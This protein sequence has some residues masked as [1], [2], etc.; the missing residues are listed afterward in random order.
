MAKKVQAKVLNYRVIIEREHYPNGTP[1]YTAFVPTLGVADYGPTIDKVLKSLKSG[2][3]LAVE[4]LV[5]AGEEVPID[6][7]EETIVVNTRVSAPK[8]TRLVPA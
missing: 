4:C 3:E 8:N 1:V 7:V 6:R 5:E 2:I